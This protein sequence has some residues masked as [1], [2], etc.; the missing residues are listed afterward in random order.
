MKHTNKRLDSSVLLVTGL[1]TVF[2]GTAMAGSGQQTESG[3]AIDCPRLT[4]AAPVSPELEK[5]RQAFFDQTVE[6]R[7]KL[8]TRRTELRAVMRAD[9]PDPARASALAA[10][11]FDLREQ[12]RKTARE[13][14]LPPQ[15]WRGN[16]HHGRWGSLPG[17]HGPHHARRLVQPE[18]EDNGAT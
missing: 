10:E 6:L 9:N 18:Q 14:E 17:G 11:I 1:L 7:R 12:L 8:M 16:G 5:K 3:P 2:A 4:A 13:L 15:F